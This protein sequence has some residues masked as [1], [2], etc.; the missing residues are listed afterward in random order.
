M[1]GMT[2]EQFKHLLIAG[3]RLAATCSS[4]SLPV[5]SSVISQTACRP[6]MMFSSFA[7]CI[8]C[9]RHTVPLHGGSSANKASLNEREWIQKI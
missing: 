6:T 4:R 3:M 7:R 8:T 2:W 1:A 5:P 9:C